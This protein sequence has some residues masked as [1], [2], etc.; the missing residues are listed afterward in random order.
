MTCLKCGRVGH[1]AANCDRQEAKVTDEPVE[2]APFVCFSF[3]DS[4][5]APADMICATDIGRRRH[6]HAQ[7]RGG[8]VSHGPSLHAH[9]AAGRSGGW[10]VIDGGATKNLGSIAA[11]QAVMDKNKMKHGTTRL[12]RVDTDRQLL[13]C[14]G[15][16]S[17]NRCISTVELGITSS[18][19]LLSVASLRALG[20]IIDV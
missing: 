7:D 2:Q 20:A 12:H 17:E 16:S 19:I 14:F 3:N 6:D 5:E 8:P 10:C 1:R 18:P 11:V 9:H 4:Q 15:N 13:F